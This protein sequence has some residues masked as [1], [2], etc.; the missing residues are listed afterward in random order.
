MEVQQ[1][2]TKI[3]VRRDTAANWTSVNPTLSAGEWGLET[4]TGRA[5]IGDGTTAWA[6]LAY[7]TMDAL[8]LATITGGLTAKATPIDAD[9]IGFWDSVTSLM[10]NFTFANL[11][12]WIQAKI[13]GAANKDALVDADKIAIVDTEAANVTKTTTW[14][15]IKAKIW[16]ALG[17]LIAGGTNKATIV[18]ADK[19]SLSDSTDS[20]TKYA[21]AA[22]WFTYISSKIGAWLAGLTDKTPPIDADNILISD[23]AATNASKKLTFANLWVWIQSKIHGAANKDALV[24]ADKFAIID[25]EAS[26]VVKT[27]TYSNL[28]TKI[29]ALFGFVSNAVGF[30]FSGGTTSKTLTVDTDATISTLTA[31]QLAA[32]IE[33]GTNT[34]T[35]NDTDVLPGVKADHSML[36]YTWT[37]I[38]AALTLDNITEGTTYKRL[39]AAEKTALSATSAQ[40]PWSAPTLYFPDQSRA[41]L[42]RISG[43]RAT[44]FYSAD[45]AKIPIQAVWVDAFTCNEASPYLSKSRANST[46]YLIG[47]WLMANS[48]LYEVTTAGTTGSSAPTYGVNLGDTVTDGTATLTLRVNSYDD[49]YP[50]FKVAGV[51][52][53][54][55]WYSRFQCVLSGANPMSI[56]GQLPASATI[57]QIRTYAARFAGCSPMGY[58]DYEILALD[59]F[60][61]GI[62]PVGNTNY[63]QSHNA[64]YKMWGGVRGDSA[65]PGNT[66][67]A[68][69]PYTRGG[70]AGFMWTHDRS[71][72]GVHDFVGNMSQWCDGAKWMDGQLYIAAHD[73]DPALFS[74]VGEDSWIATGVFLNSP[75]AGD[76]SGLSDLGTPNFDSVVTNYTA[77]VT[78][79]RDL[80]TIKADTRDLDYASGTWGSTAVSSGV[81]AL[82]AAMRL[83]AFRMGVMPKSRSNGQAPFSAQEGRLYIRNNGERFVH[84]GGYYNSTSHAG[85]RFSNANS[86]RS[87]TYAFRLVFRG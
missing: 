21:T 56:A 64:T 83:S 8:T 3:Q 86:R 52:K 41:E 9:K 24:D 48:Q 65:R 29:K 77:S 61:K 19:T 55:R 50:G 78:P 35:P 30:Q 80:A 38:K 12:T 34:A 54:G 42:E 31:S 17:G 11:W 18:D 70:S 84:R 6:T 16:T 63:G 5:K 62:T 59:A 20:S 32:A 14:A 76:D 72:W 39:L 1:V 2:A 28:K 81:D 69:N 79:T 47:E 51:S 37:Q 45:G 4:D 27:T 13:Y 46:A 25:T 60:R 82:N 57:D 49:L 23:S 44:I 75:V 58:W 22:N 43:G 68:T 33:G 40:A 87:S 36:K 26:N 10:R 67:V 53:G 73:A 15:N 66:A 71:D 7:K 74:A 85:P